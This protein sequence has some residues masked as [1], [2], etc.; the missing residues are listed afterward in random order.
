MFLDLTLRR[1]AKLIDYSIY[2][3]QAGLIEPDTYVIDL[4]TIIENG[5]L[6]LAEANRQNIDLLVMSKQYGRNPFV[7]A[8]LMKEGF[9]GTVAVDF[10]EAKVLYENGIPLTHIG[11]LVQ[12]PS[13]LVP[14]FVEMNP[15]FITVYSTQKA[16]EINEA[17]RK[18]G[19]KQKIFLRLVNEGDILYPAQYGGFYL[20][21]L[22]SVV[23]EIL[24]LSNLIIDGVTTFPCFLYEKSKG[25]IVATPNAETLRKGKEILKERFGIDIT[26]MNMPSSTCTHLI[27]MIKENGGTQGEPG[28]GLMG[29]TPMHA[30]K[31]LAERP[32]MVYVSEISHTID[33]QSYCY[34][35]GHYRRSHMENALVGK[36]L[37][38]A[39]KVSV[40][41]PDTESIDY[42]IGL[43]KELPVGDTVVMS[44]RSQV[45][46]TRS[47][48][49]VVK[50]LAG[51]TPELVGIFDSQG[52]E[53]GR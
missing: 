23:P 44:F 20:K 41:M 47:N 6:M 43:N 10:R 52:K 14:A 38:S 29:T 32:A 5:R 7:T 3:H 15:E 2:L 31:D 21:D 19:K 18:L 39:V 51:G 42:Y 16:K 12:I 30:V 49:G 24:K 33:G 9:K 8:E 36:K 25:E 1:N 22:Q 27:E 53:T 26:H 37:D 34:G 46:V 35:G 45:F 13:H 4:D 50:G 48:V 40:E 11:H 17:C 28:H